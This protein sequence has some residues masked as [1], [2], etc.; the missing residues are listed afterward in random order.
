MAEADG[1]P[2]SPARQESDSSTDSDGHSDHEFEKDLTQLR[3]PL[4]TG[5][6]SE[7]DSDPRDPVD[8]FFVVAKWQRQLRNIQ[9][10]IQESAL[11]QKGKVVAS[12]LNESRARVASTLRDRRKRL[13]QRADSRVRAFNGSV[14]K[15]LA[16]MRMKQ[17]RQAR[18]ITCF[19]CSCI[20]CVVMAFWLGRWPQTFYWWYTANSI[21]LIGC[22]AVWYRLI[23]Q[24][25]YLLDACYWV[26]GTLVAYL[27][28]FPENVW[29]FQALYGFSGMLLISVVL[30]RNS[31][32]PHSLD[33]VTSFQIHIVPVIQLWV[34]RWPSE[35][36]APTWPW[37]IPSDS[38][39]SFL[40]SFT[41]YVSWATVYYLCIWVVRR[42]TIKRKN[43]ET[44]YKLFAEDWGIEKKLPKPLR[45]PVKAKII[46]M[47][48]HILLFTAGLVAVHFPYWVQ[49]VLIC[50]A[51]IVGFKNGAT[52]YMTYFWRVYEEQITAFERQRVEAEEQMNMQLEENEP[53]DVDAINGS[54]GHAADYADDSPP[55]SVDAAEEA[56]DDS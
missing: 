25:Y 54:S 52:F 2:L 29:L 35:I 48:G 53:G 27:W 24:H 26:N 6:L 23:N 34:T 5:E 12:K 1:E 28:F 45:G 20:N 19:T 40:P 17:A 31:F 11:N 49:T 13:R 36:H 7:C 8:R 42:E 37:K 38:E 51:A 14:D 15:V 50:I 4:L 30:F 22:R 44:L 46:Y 41:L 55:R 10:G 9:R 47:F 18:H 21:W 32:V 56:D 39:M 16:K 33:R 43:Y 3:G